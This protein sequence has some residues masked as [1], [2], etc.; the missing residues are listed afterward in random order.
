MGIVVTKLRLDSWKSIAGYLDRSSRTVQRWHAHNELPVHHFGGSKGSVFAYAEE[1]DRW[2]LSL[3]GVSQNEDA[4]EENAQEERAR[5]SREL[6]TRALEMWETRSEQN[7]NTI[8]GLCRKAIELDPGNTR[9]L[10]GLADAMIASALV[11]VIDGSIAHPC[12]MEALRRTA[13]LDPEDVDGKCSA[14]WLSMVYE[15]KWRQARMHFEE[16]LTRHPRK[17]FALGG[18]ALLHIAEGDTSEAIKRAWEAWRQNTL[19]CSLGALVCWT[20]YLAGDF[21]QALELTAQVRASGGCGTW[22]GEIE[23]LI[24]IQLGPAVETIARVEAM[25]E[26]YP[27]SRTL[28]G[29]L[30]YVYASQKHA[31]KAW[32]ILRNLEQARGQKKNDAYALALISMGLEMRQDAAR[33]LEAAYAEGAIWSLGFRCDP[34]LRQME[35]DVRFETLL[36]KIGTTAGNV[37]QTSA[38][39]ERLIRAM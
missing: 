25:V 27:Q 35:G 33:W 12:A 6:T 1:I 36:R 23:G 2:Q 30:G 38:P 20:H 11:G 28:K 5:R 34:I 9:A 3:A 16:V 15:H 26:E 18:R 22:I 39:F 31:G 8:A 32:E 7:L 17:S 29:I 21:E 14:G 4:D 37:V 10:A 24:L 13:Q 19:V